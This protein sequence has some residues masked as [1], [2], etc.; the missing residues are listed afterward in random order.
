[1]SLTLH[2]WQGSEYISAFGTTQIGTTVFIK[3]K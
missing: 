3:K 1:M 2:V